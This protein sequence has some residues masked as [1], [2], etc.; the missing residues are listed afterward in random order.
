MDI[1]LKSYF[2]FCAAC[3]VVFWS[4]SLACAGTDKEHL[5]PV[6][7][8][9]LGNEHI[10]PKPVY[11]DAAGLPALTGE[12]YGAMGEHPVKKISVASPWPAYADKD[13]LK[14]DLFLP[15]DMTGKRPTVFFIT[16]YSMYHS[17]SY[18]SLLYF[19][20]SQGYNCV[21]AP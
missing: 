10:L 1:K 13:Y 3:C 12:Y 6:F 5:Q 16:G 8:L 19:M 7:H 9:L 4:M 18:Y 2:R 14:V 20:A 11:R 15:A 21:R 17:E